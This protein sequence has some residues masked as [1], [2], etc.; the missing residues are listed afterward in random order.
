MEPTSVQ[1]AVEEEVLGLRE[2]LREVDA[3]GSARGGEGA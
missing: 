2:E 1:V 3:Q